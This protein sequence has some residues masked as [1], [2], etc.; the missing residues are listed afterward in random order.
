MI[1]LIVYSQTS[2]AFDAA[3]C[4]LLLCIERCW[5]TQDANARTNLVT[6]MFTIMINGLGPLAMVFLSQT[7]EGKVAA[8]CFNYY[9]FDA[10]QELSQLLGQFKGAIAAWPSGP[11]QKSLTDIYNSMGKLTDINKV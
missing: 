7:S 4:Y 1:Y 8:P 6:N 9:P 11:V 10:G 5:A 2:L 3:Y